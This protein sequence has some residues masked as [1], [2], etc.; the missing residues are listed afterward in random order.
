MCAVLA[1]RARAVAVC[2]LLLPRG[3]TDLVAVVVVVRNRRVQSPELPEEGVRTSL[4]LLLLL[5]L[6][7]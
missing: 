7:F 4:L 3:L 5:L 6:L 2:I 1:R